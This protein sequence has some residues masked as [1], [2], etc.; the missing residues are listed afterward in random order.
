MKLKKLIKSGIKNLAVNKMRTSLAILGIVIGIGSVIALVSMGEASKKA[1][2]SQIQSIGSNLLTISPGFTSSGGVRGAFGGATT[3]TNEDA[4]A[5]KISSQITTIKNVSPEYSSRAQVVVGRNNTNTQIVGVEPVY[6]EVRKLTLSSGSFITTQHLTSTSKVAVVGPTVAEDLFGTSVNPV[7]QTIRISGKNFQIIGIT[8]SKGG[9]GMGSQ[10]DRIYIPLTTAQKQ[11]FGAKHLTSIALEAE[12]EAVMSKAQNEVGYLLLDRHNITEVTNAD[13]RI[14]SQADIL[15]TASAVTGT[16]TTLLSG[17]AAISLV[18]GGI[19]IMNI[20]LMSVTERTREIGLRKA[21][22]AKKKVI[23]QQFL[24]ESIILTFTGGLIGIGL[25]IIGF[26]IY[27]KANDS[28]FIVTLPSILLAFSVSVV[29][30]I[31]FGWYPARKASNLQP[32]E[33]LRYE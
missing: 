30:G 8:K 3:L 4:Q 25:G 33:A 13:F 14:M 5:I 18:V 12:S 7:G 20:M 29:I 17:I 1:V 31:L 15:E 28:T 19:G 32:I 16:F 23:I 9:A 2:Q 21:L 6:A 22:G 10:D 26:Y 27:S 24:I 11:L